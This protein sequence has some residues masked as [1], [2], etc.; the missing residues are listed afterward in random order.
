MIFGDCPAKKKCSHSDINCLVCYCPFYPCYKE[1]TGGRF[2]ICCGL[3]SYWERDEEVKKLGTCTYLTDGKKLMVFSN[4]R[5]Q[6]ARGS[7]WDCS[8]CHGIHKLKTI[9]EIDNISEVIINEVREWNKNN[10]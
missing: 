3:C 9:N 2:L 4:D 8:G 1:S 6:F 10:R 7:V 5:C